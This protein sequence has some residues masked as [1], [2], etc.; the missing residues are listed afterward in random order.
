M[1]FPM[2]FSQTNQSLSSALQDSLLWNGW[3]H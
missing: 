2:T 1:T 3:S